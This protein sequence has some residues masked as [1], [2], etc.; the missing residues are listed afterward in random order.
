MH[1]TCEDSL[2][3]SPLILDLAILAGASPVD[4]H[5]TRPA[6]ADQSADKTDNADKAPSPPF[7]R[8]ELLTRI[9]LRRDGESAFHGLH[10]VAS[11]LSYLTK[12]P[13]ARA[14]EALRPLPPCC[15]FHPGWSPL[16]VSHA[17]SALLRPA[18][19]GG[20]A[21]GECAGQAARDAGERAARVRG[22]AAGLVHA[23]GAQ[24]T[25]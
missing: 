6:A 22:A 25:E 3:A 17:A 19:A 11:L 4:R 1:N 13:L 20:H 8:A 9:S 18:G 21:G 7:S 23:F 15:T 2:L 10:P 12:A 24:V 14:A 5:P 16:P